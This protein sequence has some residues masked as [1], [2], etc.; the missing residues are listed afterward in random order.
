MD[1]TMIC[2]ECG[3]A[4]QPRTVV[5]KYCSLRCGERYRRKNRGKILYPSIAFQCARCGRTVVTEEG[6]RDMRTRFCSAVCEKKFWRHPP[7]ESESSRINFRSAEEYASYER[8]T[9]D[10]LEGG[11]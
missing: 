6:S 7:W 9:N 1:G 11:S 2:L 10:I 8:R 5:Q 3:A 4:F